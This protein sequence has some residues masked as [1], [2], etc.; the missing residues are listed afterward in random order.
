MRHARTS[1]WVIGFAGPGAA[2][3]EDLQVITGHPGAWGEDA[4]HLRQGAARAYPKDHGPDLRK[5]GRGWL[6]SRWSPRW[7]PGTSD[8]PHGHRPLT[9]TLPAAAG[10][11]SGTPRPNVGK[12][13]FTGWRRRD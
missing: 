8:R 4:A 6:P 10:I 13:P 5:R 11:V 7:P 1:R 2:G 9:A 12:H 3:A